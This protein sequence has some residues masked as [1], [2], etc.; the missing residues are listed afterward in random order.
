MSDMSESR[1]SG[2]RR[3]DRLV[4]EVKGGATHRLGDLLDTYRN[5]L[6]LLAST[7]IDPRLRAKVSPSDLVQETMLGAYRDFNAFQGQN[8]RQLIAW[9]RQILIHRLHVFVQQ[10]LLAERRSVRREVS[11]DD[12]A[13]ALAHSSQK[14]NAGALLADPGPSPS[15]QVIQREGA[16]R[17]ANHLQRMRPD[18]REVIML[19]NLQGLPFEEI[20]ERLGR[21]SG[22][23]RMLWLRAIQQLREQMASDPPEEADEEL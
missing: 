11:L 17:L 16:V 19:R 14:L 1:S 23:V 9:L 15:A 22:A 13:A 2:T 5:Y 18:H 21:T 4:A 8:E 20:G 12:M 10:H 6:Y 3:V 7:Q